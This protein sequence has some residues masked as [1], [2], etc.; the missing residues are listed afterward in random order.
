M[1]ISISDINVD[2]NLQPDNI[3]MLIQPNVAIWT[4]GLWQRQGWTNLIQSIWLARRY[5]MDSLPASLCPYM[6]TLCWPESMQY[7]ARAVVEWVYCLRTKWQ[8]NSSHTFHYQLY[9]QQL[10]LPNRA[11]E[12]RSNWRRLQ[13]KRSWTAQEVKR[14]STLE[15][16]FNDGDNW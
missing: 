11:R 8:R 10:V 7:T 13:T 6:P 15:W 16:L 4:Y 1:Y 3:S 12:E 5:C 9:L 2:Y 14:E